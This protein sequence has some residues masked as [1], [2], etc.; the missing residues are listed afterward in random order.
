VD[1][2]SAPPADLVALGRVRGAYGVRGGVRIEPYAA[3][4]AV[5]L[6]TRRW[7]LIGPHSPNNPNNPPGPQSLQPTGCK[8]HGTA[9]IATWP[10]CPTPEAAEAL[11]GAEV[12]V[13]RADFPPL[14]DGEFYWVDAIGAQV[15]NRQGEVLGQVQALRSNGVQDL[16]DVEQSGVSILIPLVP[17]YVDEVDVAGR[18]IRVDWQRD[19]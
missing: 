12:A 14:A 13:A 7:W 3:E 15:V 18:L 1:D 2:S 4:A 11:K 6:A 5:L 9:L 16:L 19:W 10:Q 17:V 8:R